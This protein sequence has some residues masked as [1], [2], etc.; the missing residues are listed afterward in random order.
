M[1][2]S[3]RERERVKEVGGRR[4]GDVC[5]QCGKS[6]CA[7]S[8][9]LRAV[10]WRCGDSGWG[11]PDTP[12]T[13]PAALSAASIHLAPTPYFVNKPRR[14]NSISQITLL[15]LG[16]SLFLS[17]ALLLVLVR[18]SGFASAPHWGARA[19]SSHFNSHSFWVKK[20]LWPFLRSDYCKGE[21]NFWVCVARSAR[22]PFG[23]K[24]LESF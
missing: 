16:N 4:E 14:C 20:A 9:S 24:V 19:G 6:S 11:A 22:V 3:K 13:Q 2:P 23:I 10:L 21:M 15:L 18:P 17:L 12:V 1:E 7:R 8:L 5:E